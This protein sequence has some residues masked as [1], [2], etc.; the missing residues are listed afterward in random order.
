MG[1]FF[2]RFSWLLM[3]RL[4]IPAYLRLQNLTQSL[5]FVC[6]RIL[7]HEVD[8]LMKYNRLWMVLMKGVACLIYIS[9]NYFGN[10]FFVEM[11]IIV[12][13]WCALYHLVLCRF[14]DFNVCLNMWKFR[15][16]KSYFCK[17]THFK[18]VLCL[19]PMRLTLHF[20]AWYHVD[21]N[22]ATTVY[23]LWSCMYVMYVCDCNTIHEI[24][25][26]CK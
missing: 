12:L 10:V 22:T 20:A 13:H 9:S 3:Q 7:Y 24:N 4:H 15:N 6:Q 25:W 26:P 2:A 11:L 23:M 18:T 16:V 5:H 19:Q 14:D 21:T 1:I 17:R 8:T